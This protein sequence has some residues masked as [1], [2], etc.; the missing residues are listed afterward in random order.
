M[1]EIKK[2]S[3]LLDDVELGER[4]SERGQTE[5][6]Y[7]ERIETGEKLVLKHIAIPE[8]DTKV[9]ALI[10]TGAA[11]DEAAANEYFRGLAEDLRAELAFLAS[12]PETCGVNAW[13]D[14]Q[15][16]AREGVGFD[17]YA[18]M[19][20]KDSLRSYLQD[21]AI[22]QL[23]ALNLGLDLCD[24]MGNLNDTG[25]AYFDLKPENVFVD[26]RKRFTIGDLGLMQL[27][28]LE[29]SAVPEEHINEFSAPEL[30]KLIP[31]P[32]RTSDQYSLGMLLF[33]VFN[34]NRLPFEDEK[35][36]A[37]RAVEKRLNSDI[38]PSPQ[39]ADYELAEIIS[40]ACSRDP[41]A[42]Y[43][44]FAELK[45]ALTLY[46]QRNEVSDQLLVPPLPEPIASQTEEAAEKPDAA[47][48]GEELPEAPQTE[49]A[50]AAL[51]ESPE[52]EEAQNKEEPHD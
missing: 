11:A 40:K 43:A 22:T 48:P 3:P 9:Q 1:S 19:P 52:P 41:A 12:V 32:A 33:Y 30:S 35:I 8:S 45:Q 18:L 37:Q 39:Y 23:Q 31:E 42:R 27:D 46:M 2:V 28:G 47:E 17:V 5:C 4:F 13:L 26:A 6:F 10:L 20:R 50:E 38:L 21:N 44:S 51:P 29:Y 25:Y 34:G 15:I 36:S 7:C 14:Y 16:E 49:P 24:A